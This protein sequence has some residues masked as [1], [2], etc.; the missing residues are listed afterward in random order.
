MTPKEK[1]KELIEKMIM[2]D[3][4]FDKMQ[5]KHCAT[6][7]VNEIIADLKGYRLKPYFTVKQTVDASVFWEQVK[8]EINNL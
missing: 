4:A 3:N 5:Q 1:A 7:C 8:T 6:A 2:R